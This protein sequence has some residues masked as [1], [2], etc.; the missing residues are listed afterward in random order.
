MTGSS[1]AHACHVTDHGRSTVLPRL[2]AE[3]KLPE[4]LL[5]D[6]V[7]TSA[8]EAIADIPDG[9]SL[10]VDGFGLS[11]VPTVLIKALHTHGATGLMDHTA[12]D[13]SSKIVMECGLPLTGEGC[14]HRIITDLG[15]LDVT[16][17]G[18]VLVETAP[19]VTFEHVAA[20]TGSPLQAGG[21][22]EAAHTSRCGSPR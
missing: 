7:S 9:A 16:P 3:T 5:V 4:G 17:D 13:G 20:R 6:K 22:N 2:L 21:L 11:G 19:G 8:A 1:T 12:K 14:V 18:L 10:A 15:V